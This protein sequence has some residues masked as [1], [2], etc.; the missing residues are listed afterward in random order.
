LESRK[1]PP[2]IAI[3]KGLT[4]EERLPIWLAKMTAACDLTGTVGGAVDA[5]ELTNWG[6]I[7]WLRKKGNCPENID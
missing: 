2:N 4:V 6:K 3:D 1:Q 7:R 5:L